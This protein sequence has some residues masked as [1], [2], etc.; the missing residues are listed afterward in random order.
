[1]AIAYYETGQLDKAEEMASQALHLDPNRVLAHTLLGV[2]ALGARRPEKGLPYLRHAVSL[3]AGYGQAH[4]FL[5][6]AYK[7]LDQ[8]A[9]AIASF[10]E[11]LVNAD[12]EVMRT[13]IRRHLSEL[14]EAQDRS[15]A[16]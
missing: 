16:D 11:A 4:F 1:M 14:Y 8:P 13:R 7:S 5:G 15:K 6:L 2:V 10:E 9:E 3:D 12:D